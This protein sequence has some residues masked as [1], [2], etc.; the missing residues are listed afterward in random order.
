MIGFRP[1]LPAK[2]PAKGL[3]IRAPRL[4][5]EVIK[6]LSKVVRVPQFLANG[7]ED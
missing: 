6:L 7:N 5:Q 2:S 3:A 1:I 4:V